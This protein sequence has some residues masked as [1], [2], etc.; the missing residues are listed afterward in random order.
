MSIE[1]NKELVRRIEHAWDSG[2]LDALDELFHPDVT[3][4]ASVPFLP[5][6][7]EGWKISHLAM[8]RAVPDRK[9]TIEDMIA[10]GDRVAVRCRLRGTNL[11]GLAWAGA[12]PNGGPIDMEWITIYQIEQGKVKRCWALNDMSTL[13]RQIGAPEELIARRIL[14]GGW[15][16]LRDTRVAPPVGA[17]EARGKG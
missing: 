11:G 14:R 9:V 3:S 13:V 16:V 5:P 10:E 6:G 15:P 4:N 12:A 1:E 8:H 17:D 7:L 2:D